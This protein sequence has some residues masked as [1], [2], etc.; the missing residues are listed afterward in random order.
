MG[1]DLSQVAEPQCCDTRKPDEHVSVQAK[2]PAAVPRMPPPGQTPLELGKK[3]VSQ[4][5]GVGL[6]FRTGRDGKL[7]VASFIKESSA[8]DCGLVR[9]GDVLC[10]VNGQEVGNIPPAFLDRIL[11]GDKGTWVQMRFLRQTDARGSGKGSGGGTDRSQ[12]AVLGK[13]VEETKWASSTMRSFA[14]TYQSLVVDL[15]RTTPSVI[16]SEA[17][18]QAHDEDVA[19][20]GRRGVVSHR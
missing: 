20:R 19:R 6:V 5:H 11:L 3:A 2:T 13:S 14:P 16:L 7:V 8:Y 1:N 12:E 9:D 18:S 15:C 4:P 17:V 10:A